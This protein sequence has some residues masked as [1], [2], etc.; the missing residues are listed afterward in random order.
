MMSIIQD[1]EIEC[2]ESATLQVNVM[3]GYGTYTVT[4]SN[5]DIGNPYIVSPQVETTYFYTATDTCGTTPSTGSVTVSFVD[6]PPL[7]VDAGPDL[8][9]SCL[10]TVLVNPNVE[11]GSGEYTYQWEVNG[12]PVSTDEVLSLNTD[13]AGDVTLIV[14]DECLETASDQLSF[15]FPP[16][17]V[18]VELGDDIDVTCLDVSEIFAQT[19]GGIGNYTYSW[20]V[21]GEVLGSQNPIDVQVA[22][23]TVVTVTV[24]DECENVGTDQMTINL[25]PLAIDVLVDNSINANCITPF[26]ANAGGSGGAGSYSYEWELNGQVLSSTNSLTYQTDNPINIEITV[27]DEC[28]NSGTETVVVSMPAVPVNVSTSGNQT[29]CQGESVDI[30]ATANGGLGDLTY[31]WT[32][33]GEGEEINVSPQ[34]TTSYQVVVEDEC[35]NENSSSLTINV[36]EPQGEFTVVED[37]DICFGVESGIIVSGGVPPY[38]FDYS[39]DSLISANAGQ[40]TG[41]YL[42][43]Y[44]IVINDQC[45]GAGEVNVH[46]EQCSIIIPNIFTPNQDGKNETFFIDGLFGFPNSKL[47]VFNRWGNEVY[48]SED[49][50]GSWDGGDVPSGVYFYILNRS[51][52]EDFEG[53]VHILKD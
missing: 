35:G 9:F 12:E 42:G 21:G 51:D 17:P 28:G 38:E 2:G 19:S 8:E 44:T 13:D 49:Y 31:E 16:V 33:L 47:T 5:G 1:Q 4:W 11:G 25:P 40:F 3:G 37:F 43:D 22:E 26:T 6:Y 53:Y 52:G 45:F 46:V 14:T 18:F 34:S 23:Q 39:I 48:S 10:E 7:V 30:S 36:L 27:T 32:G 41:L 29:I 50:S 20:D 24:L 15:T